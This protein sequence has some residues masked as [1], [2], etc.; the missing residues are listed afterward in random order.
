MTK[1]LSL[2]FLA[3]AA[4]CFTSCTKEDDY[5]KFQEGGEITYA[6][7]ADS[8]I[9]YPGNQRVLLSIALGNDPL[10]NKVKVYWN[11]RKDSTLVSVKRTSGKDTVKLYINNLT[12]GTYNFNIYT[13]DTKNHSSVVKNVSGSVYGANYSGSLTSRNLSALSYVEDGTTVALGWG[14]RGT[15]ETR[16]EIKYT[17]SSGTE[18]TVILTPEQQAALLQDVKDNTSMTYRTFFKPDTLAIDSFATALTTVKLVFPAFE[19]SLDKSK[20]KEVILPA[21][22]VEGGYGWLM[23]YLWD[24][25]YNPDGFATED[26]VDGKPQSF[27]FDTGVSTSFSRMKMW[28]A[29][30]RLY[31]LQSVKKFEVWGS[32]NPDPDGSWE[33]WNKLLTCTSVKPS[34]APVGTN[35]P[36]DIAYAKAGEEFV[37]PA[38][39][40]KYRY[41]RIKM[42]ENWGGGTFMTMEELTFWTHDR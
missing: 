35:T 9:V 19:R 30:D 38:G 26:I 27:T 1:Y 23:E 5:K 24:D 41:V 14:A 8:A 29:N 31:D 10:V 36:A 40:P 17:Q 22:A 34:G 13:Y 42:L 7:R 3:A 4:L 11:D 39:T 32:N 2:L 21:D 20:F 37:F 18:K 12:E 6:G 25:N 33:S 28:Q 16:T 15:G